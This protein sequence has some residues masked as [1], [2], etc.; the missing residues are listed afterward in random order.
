M[1]RQSP[2]TI[3]YFKTRYLWLK[4]TCALLLL[5]GLGMR[6][7]CVLFHFQPLAALAG[8]ADGAPAGRLGTVPVEARGC[9]PP[10]PP[11][12]FGKLAKTR[13]PPR[14]HGA[15]RVQQVPSWARPCK[16][17]KSRQE[18]KGR[19]RGGTGCTTRFSKAMAKFSLRENGH[20]LL[21]KNSPLQVLVTRNSLGGEGRA[22]G[23]L[24][25]VR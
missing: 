5:F 7:C 10:E 22:L 11:A 15:G 21:F 12:F 8:V 4:C 18:G 24:L 20:T 17:S 3:C 6:G 16:T 2:N 25:H 19:W 23:A 13:F 9:C 1:K 14:T